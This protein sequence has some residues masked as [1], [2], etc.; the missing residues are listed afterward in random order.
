MVWVA[1]LAHVSAANSAA[2]FNVA[3]LAGLSVS[4]CLYVLAIFFGVKR[5]DQDSA[6]TCH[7]LFHLAGSLTNVCCLYPAVD[8]WRRRQQFL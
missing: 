7:V 5:K 6:S 2:T 8:D 4:G 3:Y 1:L